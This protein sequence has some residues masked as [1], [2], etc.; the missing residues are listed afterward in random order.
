[1]AC[2]PR[3]PLCIH[4]HS[5]PTPTAVSVCAQSPTD[6]LLTL[7]AV[8]LPLTHHPHASIQL[9]PFSVSVLLGLILE[10]QSKD[11]Y[12]I[13]PCNPSFHEMNLHEILYSYTTHYTIFPPI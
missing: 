9:A 3:L 5:V 1:M 11:W 10:F 7:V 4:T 12:R 8:C 13:L 6:L 2:D